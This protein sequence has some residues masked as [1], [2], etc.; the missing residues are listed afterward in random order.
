MK[1]TSVQTIKFSFTEEIIDQLATVLDETPARVQKGLAKS[2]PLVLD[3]LLKQA[4]PEGSPSALLQLAREADAS[5]VPMQL[6]DVGSPMWYEQGGAILVELLGSAYGSS[7]N[8]LAQE[9]GLQLLAAE[10]IMQLT[11]AAVLNVVGHYAAEHGLTPSA[12]VQWLATQKT[13]IEAAM[14]PTLQPASAPTMRA[15]APMPPRLLPATP[16]RPMPAGAW[17]GAAPAAAP[18]GGA[19]WPWQWGLLLLLAV[20]LGYFF[21]YDRRQP[22]GEEQPSVAK[23]AAPAA[24][25]APAAPEVGVASG[26]YDQNRDTYIYDTGQP[27]VLKLADGTTQKVGV[28]STENRLYTFLATPTVQVDSVNRTKGWINFD[29]VYF[30]AGKATLTPE[31]AQQLHNVASILKAFPKAVVKIGGYTDSSGVALHNFQ[32]SEERAKTA[33]VTLGTL[34]VP[35]DNLQYK[36][37][38]ARYFVTSNS[39]LAGRAL[40]RRISIRVLKK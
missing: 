34:G 11:A 4:E 29:R 40:N 38:G 27:I 33:M 8:E 1:T 23:A 3:T 19:N 5:S 10:R 35:I 32:L 2:V 7:M 25:A 12:F 39:T 18:R 28:N 13:S 14:L 24:L 22:V 16:P 21:G 30:E 20:S 26:R 6:A 15:P 36:G 37:Y 9:A 17:P 31:S